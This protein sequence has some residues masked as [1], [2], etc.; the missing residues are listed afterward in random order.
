M[1]V[2]EKTNQLDAFKGF[3]RSSRAVVDECG[4][5]NKELLA[6][7]MLNLYPLYENLYTLSKFSGEVSQYIQLTKLFT[8]CNAE[9][10]IRCQKMTTE[11][12]IIEF[13]KYLD[14]LDKP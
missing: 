5:M 7:K 13:R 6:V 12:Y 14:D 4:F 3:I 2:E 9:E 10:M 11:E 1:S 8:Q